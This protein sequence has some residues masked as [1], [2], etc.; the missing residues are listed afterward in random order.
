MDEHSGYPYPSMTPQSLLPPLSNPLSAGP[1]SS[2]AHQA[3]SGPAPAAAASAPGSGLQAR[4]A[5]T[6]LAPS[7][8]SAYQQQLAQASDLMRFDDDGE[9][10]S[11]S[12][13]GNR[14]PHGA[15][16]AFIPHDDGAFSSA[17][18]LHQHQH[19]SSSSSKGPESSKARNG[20]GGG[21]G[22]SS[23][24]TSK[25]PNATASSTANG[26]ISSSSGVGGQGRS[27]R[28]RRSAATRAPKYAELDASDN[29]FELEL[30]RA[31]RSSN[32]DAGNGDDP[33]SDNDDDER[34]GD[35]SGGEEEQRQQQ[36]DDDEDEMRIP[37]ASA[38][39]TM[40]AG[41]K[42]RRRTS[43]VGPAARTLEG[44]RRAAAARSNGLAMGNDQQ[45]LYG[46]LASGPAHHAS[47][48]NGQQQY[49][50]ATMALGNGQ[51]DGAQEDEPTMS[52]A[53]WVKVSADDEDAYMS[54]GALDLAH[55]HSYDDDDDDAAAAAAA[56]GQAILNG[57]AL[58]GH[59]NGGANNEHSNAA[60]PASASTS[61]GGSASG[62]A[63]VSA[64]ASASVSGSATAS[65]SGTRG[66]RRARGAARPAASR[67]ASAS[68]GLAGPS[69]S[70]ALAGPSASASTAATEAM[71]DAHDDPAVLAGAGAT[72]DA[73]PLYV[74]AKQY[75]RI[76]KRRVARARL[77]E[78]G[79]LSRERKV[80]HSAAVSSAVLSGLLIVF[81]LNVAALPARVE[82][83][84]RHASASRTRWPLPHTRRDGGDGVHQEE[85]RHRG[86]CRC[87][88]CPCSYCLVLLVCD[89][90]GLG[91][92]R[93]WRIDVECRRKTG[94]WASASWHANFS[95]ELDGP[96][97]HL[98]QMAAQACLVVLA[99]L[100]LRHL[101][102]TKPSLLVAA[103][104][105]L[106]P[107][108]HP[109]V[110]QP[111][112]STL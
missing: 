108:D 102:T 61:A 111:L 7:A 51:A 93:E 34:D 105:F 103:I 65:G 3:P 104:S 32:H 63:S 77:E 18:P 100:R 95:R 22:K 45:Q 71:L 88:R 47:G 97:A 14:F 20:S 64:S 6:L 75:H 72:G 99:A 46:A 96:S 25:R 112:R 54:G 56:Q 82:A 1:S 26:H 78:M 68:N 8:L 84:A 101:I 35:G 107:R 110:T 60:S 30:E 57:H 62:S 70:A 67:S 92:R 73:E 11:L 17:G 81:W 49:L 59:G 87:R 83:Q 41:T 53:D 50:D 28:P 86:S 15:S 69:S 36:D 58:N 9:S 27:G 44:K 39:S 55:G 90:F 80:R 43:S 76:L 74:N 10:P 37:S 40:M 38:S 79:R 52:I 85:G 106:V 89:C 24:S 31:Q 29:E 91:A 5:N 12:S 42:R 4:G 23:S 13:I 66:A 33:A 19:V 98:T 16:S 48:S 94:Q 2:S 21:G 109:S